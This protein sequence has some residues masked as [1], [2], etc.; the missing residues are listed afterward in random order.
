MRRYTTALTI[1][2]SDSSG[3][4]GIQAD[5]KT[6]SALG[7]YGMTAITAITVQNTLGVT[8]VQGI[9]PSIVAGQIDAVYS[10]IR[11]DAVK[12]G[13]LFST[14]IV[15][16]V[17][18]SLTRNNARNVVLDPVMVSTSGCK[19]ISDDAIN[20]IRSRLLPLC[21]IV[22]PNVAEAVELTGSEN[23]EE[24]IQALRMMGANAILLKGGD[25]EGEGLSRQSV[26]MLSISAISPSVKLS[27]ERVST[28]NTHGTGCT[29]SSAIASFLALGYPIERAVISAKRYIYD[30][31]TTGANI[32]IGNG[33]GPVNHLF[34]P[35]PLIIN[36]F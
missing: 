6:M 1:A 5:L 31:L 34:S 25:S 22:T 32:S 16:A 19:L 20:M 28:C 8:A 2:G 14:E 35:V 18:D 36:E 7:V 3:G 30:A 11:P 26:D 33:N 4:A 12:I 15:E 23:P 29:L 27:S 13:M 10:D 17:A 24:Q 21:M 9:S